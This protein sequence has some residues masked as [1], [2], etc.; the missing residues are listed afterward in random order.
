MAEADRRREL[1]ALRRRLASLKVR[2]EATRQKAADTREQLEAAEANLELRT[3]ERRV[4]EIRAVEA[5]RAAGKAQADRD[6]ALRQSVALR[7]DLAARLAALYRMG[8]LGYLQTLASADSGEAFLRGL[9]LLTYLAGRDARLLH[10]YE[11]SLAELGVR[12]RNLA[13]LRAS[14]ASVAAETREAERALQRARAEKAAL[15]ARLERSAEEQRSSVVALEDK[16]SRLEAL[17]ELLETRGRALPAG[18]ASIRKYKGALD[19]PAP[20]KV[21]VP[22]GRIANPRFPKTFLRSSGWTIDVPTG[23]AVRAVFAGDVVY[24]QWLKGYGNLVV[25]DHGDGVFT[26][27][28]HL[29]TGTAPRGTRVALGEVVGRV[30]DPPEDEVPGVYFEIRE[31]RTSVDPRGWLR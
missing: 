15:L 24:A 21:V 31:S 6:D 1:A 23:T 30:A 20:G 8:R 12:E 25:L 22:F 16:T 27:Y 7:E 17:L 19:W 26:L 10:A 14:I 3:T 5:E 2:Y 4:L 9:Q 18:V 29:L 13:T 28:G 11:G